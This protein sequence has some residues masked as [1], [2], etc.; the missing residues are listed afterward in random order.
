MPQSTRIH[1]DA[2]MTEISV[3][4]KNDGLIS[5]S[6]PEVNVVH[7]TNDYYVF[8]KSN[9]RREKTIWAKGGYPARTSWELSTQSYSLKRHALE[10]LVYDEDR[11]NQDPAV[12]L[13]IQTT[14]DLTDKI[15]LEQEADLS[16]LIGLASNWANATSLTSTFAWSA[17]TTLS[18]PIL[19]VDSATAVISQNTGKKANVTVMNLPTWNATKEHISIVD[20]IKHT[21]RDSV[22]HEMVAKLFGVEKLLVSS[23]VEN[24][25][26][27][28]LADSMNFLLTDCAWV[29]YVEMSPGLRKP[30]AL[31]RFTKRGDGGSGV[32][33]FRYRDDRAEADVLRAKKRWQHKSPASDCAYHINNTVQ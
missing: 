24:T 27:E 18:N 5:P 26:E 17:N 7:N 31:Y 8:T 16:S 4:Y 13:D 11:E 15:L 29:A 33:M 1:K 25:G 3:A 10:E 22:S 30:S 9:F 23:A 28:G 32:R 19:F 20:R 21:S 14:E 6:F 2:A 12:Q